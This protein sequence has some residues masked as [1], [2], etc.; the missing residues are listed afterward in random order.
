MTTQV[1]VL[2]TALLV[3]MLVIDRLARSQVV[4]KPRW[5]AGPMFTGAPT[6]RKRGP[7]AR[8]PHMTTSVAV[9]ALAS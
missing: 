8:A 2:A 6:L 4:L 1:V 5:T 3:A 9:L 7:V